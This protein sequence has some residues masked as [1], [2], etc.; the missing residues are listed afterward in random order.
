MKKI[1]LVFFLLLVINVKAAI[2]G[3][4]NND[5]KITSQ[6]YILV[7]RHIMKLSLLSTIE[8]TRAD[9]NND[10]LITS[11]DYI[12]I[13][14]VI[15]D[16]STPTPSPT[17]APTPVLTPEEKICENSKAAGSV[18][19]ASFASF[20]KDNDDYYVIKTAHD[21]ANKYNLPVSV[22]KGIYHIYKKNNETISV[23]TNTNFNDS[24]IYVHDE[25][26]TIYNYIDSNIFKIEPNKNEACEQLTM[27][28]F[29]NAFTSLAPSTGKYFVYITEQNGDKVY[30]R[31]KGGSI[32]QEKNKREALRIY[33]GVVQDPI[34]WN[35]HNSTIK[36]SRCPIPSQQL[37][38]ENANFRTMVRVDCDKCGDGYAKRSIALTRSNTK[39]SN[40]KHYYVDKNDKN[41]YEIHHRYHSFIEISKVADTLVENSMIYPLYYN[42][43]SGRD[44]TYDMTI[45]SSVNVELDGVKMYE[46]S[47]HNQMNDED[48]WSVMT[49][50][51]CKNLTVNNSYLNTVSAHTNV[52]NL[53]VRNTTLGSRGVI[54]TGTGDRQDNMINIENV[55]WRYGDYLIRLRVDYGATWN[56]TISIKNSKIS[57]VSSST[58]TGV[59]LEAISNN[60]GKKFGQPICNPTKVTIDG[61]EIKTSKVNKFRVFN[62]SKSDYE[63]YYFKVF[64]RKTNKNESTKISKNSIIG[65]SKLTIV[66][67]D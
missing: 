14:K 48:Y 63:N 27:N 58:V 1:V 55:T 7:R 60:I 51:E 34:T 22:T 59:K 45:H 50:Y 49:T 40:I 25:Y 4:V 32:V 15:M 36:Y 6:D 26:S 42:G 31:N 39:I 2:L 16:G 24:T 21:C 66:N 35:Y 37:Q 33:D 44:S 57:H 30:H 52:Y 62:E 54:V 13:R 65:A 56:G 23:Q 41:V 5:G 43:S 12:L 8:E 17:Q 61:L 20:K 53:T 46:D 11:A 38:F 19:Y 64:Q 47:T 67:Y 3:D 18:D 28:N 29:N 9:M 10:N